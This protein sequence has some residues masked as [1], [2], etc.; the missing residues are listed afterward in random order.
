MEGGTAVDQERR[1]M[2]GDF[3][4]K[5]GRSLWHLRSW[6]RHDVILLVAGLIYVLVGVS[7][8][9]RDEPSP[10][11]YIALEVLLRVASLK[12][13]G[14]LFL[15][16]GTLCMVS[17]RWPPHNDSWGYMIL[18]GLSLGWGSA[19]LM[20]VIFLGSPWININGFFVWGLLGF[21]WWA[22]SGLLNPD[23]TAVIHDDRPG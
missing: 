2:E 15:A 1:N 7:Y 18:T 5:A 22:V 14:G 4:M 10:D 20:G 12:F 11:Q 21:L 16:A 17:S 9:L 6:K 3:P 8:I 19:Y 23:K 13:Y